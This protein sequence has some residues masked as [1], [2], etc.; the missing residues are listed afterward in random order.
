MQSWG[1][2]RLHPVLRLPHSGR[3]SSG[4]ASADF[5][6]HHLQGLERERQRREKRGGKREEREEGRERKGR[7][8]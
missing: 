8:G 5:I 3:H 2:H 6:H 4:G 1:P 7:E